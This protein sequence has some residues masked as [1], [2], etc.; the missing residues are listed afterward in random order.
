LVSVVKFIIEK[1]QAFKDDENVGSLRTFF[2]QKFQ[3]FLQAK[4]QKRCDVSAD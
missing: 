1:G 4:F 2:Q 3:N